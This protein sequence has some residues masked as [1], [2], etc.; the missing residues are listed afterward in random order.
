MPR[1][2]LCGKKVR[3]AFQCSHCGGRF[4][5]EHKSPWAHGCRALSEAVTW[6]AI[7]PRM[8]LPTVKGKLAKNEVNEVKR[9]EVE[10]NEYLRNLLEDRLDQTIDFGE[11][12]SVHD[13][14][15]YFYDLFGSDLFFDSL[16][17]IIQQYSLADVEI[18]TKTGKSTVNTGFNLALFGEPGTG[19][20]FATRD[21]IVGRKGKGVP[22]H[23][24]PG[25]NRYCGGMTPARF[26]EI[27]QAY[28]GRRFNFMV[29]EF[30]DW[31]KYTG[32]VEP[33]KLAMER[34]MI[35]KETARQTIGPYKF[36]SFFSVNYNVKAKERG[37]RAAMGD[38]NF[39]AIEDR[40]LCRLHRLTRERYHSIAESQMKLALG[41]I[42]FDLA[43]QI[44][45]HLTLI[46][47]VQTR[48][49]LVTEYFPYKPV[50]LTEKAYK[51]VAEARETILEH[52]KYKERLDFS[53][54]LEMRAIQFACAS[55]LPCYFKENK[56][57]IEID[58]EALKLA[59]RFYV[60][61]G[62]VRSEEEYDPK[63]VLY[64]LGI[65]QA[66]RQQ[67]NH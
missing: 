6:E 55:S 42:D 60:E 45:D 53:P 46:H 29:T 49:P 24:L 47:A 48:H 28:E 62:A 32:M 41:K 58:S 51:K 18:T 56:E 44:R 50:L 14:A 4:C 9:L 21:M 37:Y 40:M 39:N 63:L 2:D 7:K 22:A 57:Y 17:S 1:C 35:R 26:M 10:F 54:R 23:G 30:K 8:P 3:L 5:S 12:F 16:L 36:T 15:L 43:S 65:S 61:E 33:L 27:G 13:L 25:R 38:P 67:N 11:K 64:D 19:K 59:I 34:G 31:F 20:T 52:L 66:I